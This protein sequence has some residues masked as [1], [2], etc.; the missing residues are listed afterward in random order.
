M[1]RRLPKVTVPLTPREFGELAQLLFEW[2]IRRAPRLALPFFIL[3]AMFMQAGVI[4]LFSIRY[5]VPAGR[6]PESPRFYFIPSG[7]E[8][9]N[10]L[11]PWL[12]ANDPSIF[13]PSRATAAAVPAPPPLR[14]RPSYE[15]P[16]PPPRPLPP[17]KERTLEPPELPLVGEASRGIRSKPAAIPVLQSGKTTVQWMDGLSNRSP[18]EPESAPQVGF[19]GAVEPSSYQVGVAS[20]GEILCCV[21]TASSGDPAIDDSGRSWILSRKFPPEKGVSW[22]R[23][24]IHWSLGPVKKTEKTSRP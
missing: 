1:T 13:S 8:A 4:F 19:T 16:P 22:G 23:V 10:R 18:S 11:A 5:G 9:A 20:D 6:L 15:E 3:M 7:S 17:E 21:L 2:P 14:Y 12:E 24:L